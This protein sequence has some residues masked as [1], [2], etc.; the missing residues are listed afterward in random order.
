MLIG[1]KIITM[2]REEG[3]MA[4]GPSASPITRT[5]LLNCDWSASGKTCTSPLRR[6]TLCR[7][8]IYV[9]PSFQSLTHPCLRPQHE[10]GPS[11]ETPLPPQVSGTF[12]G[13]FHMQNARSYDNL[14]TTRCTS[15]MIC[16]KTV[17]EIND[18]KVI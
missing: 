15:C 6:R 14:S 2:E 5:L 16:G 12:R 8:S 17:D 10:R 7:G 3:E 11:V 1:G 13:S 18:D 4:P 9:T